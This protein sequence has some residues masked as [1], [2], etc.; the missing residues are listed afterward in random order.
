[1]AFVRKP[2]HFDAFADQVSQIVRNWVR[3]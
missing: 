1:M 3:G 2:N